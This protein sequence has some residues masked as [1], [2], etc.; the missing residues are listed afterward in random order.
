M[1]RNMN[2]RAAEYLEAI[3]YLPAGSV[4]AFEDVT[5]DEYEQLLDDLAERPHFRLSYDCGRLEI[6]S[7]GS[8]HEGAAALIAD[9]VRFVSDTENLNLENYGRTTWRRKNLQR[10]LEPDICFYIA[11]AARVIG[12]RRIDLKRDPPPDIAVEI[13]ITHRSVSK[14]PIYAALLIPE[15]WIYDG[16]AFRVYAL[17]GTSY[18]ETTR[19]QF[20]P[21]LNPDHVRTALKR[22]K[23]VGQSAALR[24]FR[25]M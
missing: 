13:D 17:N 20:L 16:N 9:V 23:S 2:S 6:V 8:D 22:S 25:T 4:L 21:S 24:E 11:N 15:I 19:S 14:F 18:E 1:M 5:W 12:R 7:P 10:G 3:N